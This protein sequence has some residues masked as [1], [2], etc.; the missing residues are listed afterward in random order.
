MAGVDHCDQMLSQCH[1]YDV[2]FVLPIQT[3]LSVIEKL[4]GPPPA[5]PLPKVRIT[6]LPELCPKGEGSRAKRRRCQVCWEN[7]SQK[8]FYLLLSFVPESTRTML[9]TLFSI[10]SFQKLI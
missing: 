9:S 6:H 2:E 3:R 8:R 7:N 10:I 4:L 5:E 1:I